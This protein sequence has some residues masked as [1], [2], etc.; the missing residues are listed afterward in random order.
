MKYTFKQIVQ[1]FLRKFLGTQFGRIHYLRLDINVDNT[2]ANLENFDLSVKELVYEDFLLGNKLAFHK[3]KLDL[4][5][6]RF[7]DPNY[8]AYGI[9]EN[10]HLIYSTW[11]STE[12]LGLPVQL[13]NPISLL[14]HEGLLEDSYCDPIARGRRL[15]SNMNNYRILKL[16]ELGKTQVLALVLKGN[17]PAFKVQLKS[18]FKKL[19]CF[20][21]G[22][23]LWMNFATLKKEKFD[24]IS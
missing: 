14:P 24:R 23:I 17:T 9:I 22:K 6:E 21:C 11:I 7:N 3:K 10:G 5:K 4:I 1:A 19:G 18:G 20:Y 8:K 16:H 12:R 13:K 15:H 2:K